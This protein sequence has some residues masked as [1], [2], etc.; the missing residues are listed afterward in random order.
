MASADAIEGIASKVRVFA[1]LT[2]AHSV[3]ANRTRQN[4]H[5][6]DVSLP[7]YAAVG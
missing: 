5:A 7:C 6:F 3:N 4:G 2:S 1:N